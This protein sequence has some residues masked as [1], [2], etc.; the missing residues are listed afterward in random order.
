MGARLSLVPVMTLLA[1]SAGAGALMAQGSPP[2]A[3]I[4][5]PEGVIVPKLPTGPAQNHPA[6]SPAP[7]TGPVAV[8]SSPEPSPNVFAVTTAPTT[9]AI[10]MPVAVT[11]ETKGECPQFKLDFGD[12]TTGTSAGAAVATNA[13]NYRYTVHHSYAAV[14]KK[15]IAAT[16]LMK[17]KGTAVGEADIVTAVVNGNTPDLPPKPWSWRI[18]AKRWRIQWMFSPVTDDVAPRSVSGDAYSDL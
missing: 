3:G 15:T 2:S 11:V 13:G 7:P 9:V 1:V 18:T 4:R 17:C 5:R 10:N 6:T 14:G 12:G 16:G 8:P